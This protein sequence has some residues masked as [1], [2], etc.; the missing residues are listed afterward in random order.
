MINTLSIFGKINRLY[1]VV[2]AFISTILSYHTSLKTALEAFAVITLLD[3]LTR[4]NTEAKKQGLKFNPFK[5]YFYQQIQS[6]GL[7]MMC[8]KIFAE[9]GVYIIVAFVIDYWVLNQM[10]LLKF[11]DRGLTLP[12]IS[13]YIF[14]GIEI[15]SIGENIEE[16]GGINIIKRILHFLPEKIQKIFNSDKTTL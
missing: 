1:L 4:I 11:N 2:T 13:L 16:A 12:I 7:R 5:K 6:K 14:S 15:W 8:D 3:T 10:V 9:Y